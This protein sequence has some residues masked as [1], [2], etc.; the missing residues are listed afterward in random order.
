MLRYFAKEI[1]F[2]LSLWDEGRPQLDFNL[3]VAEWANL[4]FDLLPL[5]TCIADVN[6][7]LTCFP[8]TLLNGVSKDLIC[9]NFLE[10]LPRNSLSFWK[11]FH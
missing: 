4:S 3:D 10:L 5:K 9:C 11:I 7:R 2:S 1:Y 6:P 8:A